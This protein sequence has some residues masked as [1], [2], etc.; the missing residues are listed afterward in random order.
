MFNDLGH[1]WLDHG[2]IGLGIVLGHTTLIVQL[3]EQLSH[4]RQAVPRLVQRSRDRWTCSKWDKL[5]KEYS[6]RKN[7]IA[8]RRRVAMRVVFL[9]IVSITG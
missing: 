9:F 1:R 2:T 7:D 8:T 6:P 3:G 4:I 5:V